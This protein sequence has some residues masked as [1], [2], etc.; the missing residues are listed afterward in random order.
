MGRSR[1]SNANMTHSR[2]SGC[3]LG[4]PTYQPSGVAYYLP[5]SMLFIEFRLLPFVSLVISIY[6]L[7]QA[8]RGRES[9]ALAL[10]AFSAGALA[11]VYFE[12][13]LYAATQDVLIGSLAHE[14]AEFWFLV[15][16]AEFLRRSFPLATTDKA[17]GS[18]TSEPPVTT[19][20]AGS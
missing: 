14:V 1:V 10:M 16:M 6:A 5:S 18:D 17:T 11:Y 9:R 19:R 2:R 12:M 3:S 8:R 7:A 13:V 15:A 20:A 4:R